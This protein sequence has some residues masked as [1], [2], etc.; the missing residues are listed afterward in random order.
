MLVFAVAMSAWM[1]IGGLAKD[2]SDV[3]GDRAAGRHTLP[4]LWGERRAK[5][6]IATAATAVG[7]AFFLAALTV[8][9]GLLFV[10]GLVLTGSV[11]LAVVA[12][13]RWSKGDRVAQRGRTVSS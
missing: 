5:L 6:A 10:A 4:L 12:L 3:A 13:G 2:L 7:A 11:V 1:G 9:P 8:A